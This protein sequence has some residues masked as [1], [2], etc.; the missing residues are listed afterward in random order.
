[1]EKKPRTTLLE[2]IPLTEED[3]EREQEKENDPYPQ[4][5]AIWHTHFFSARKL[6]RRLPLWE[7][8]SLPPVANSAANWQTN[9]GI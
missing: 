5:L 3:Y 6:I 8:L 1:M 9:F 7:T 2:W 4:N